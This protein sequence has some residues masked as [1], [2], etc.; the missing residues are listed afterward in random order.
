[1]K[2]STEDNIENVLDRSETERIVRSAALI[3][4]GLGIVNI[5][6]VMALAMM[7]LKVQIR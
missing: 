4:I 5:M 3:A 1:M 6:I 7:L 2:R